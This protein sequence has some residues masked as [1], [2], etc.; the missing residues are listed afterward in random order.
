MK[1]AAGTPFVHP[2]LIG[3]GQV[4]HTRLKPVHHAFVYGTYFLLLPMRSLQRTPAP[5]LARNRWAPLSFADADHGDGRG[6]E[7]GGALAWLDALLQTEGITDAQGEVWL[8]TYPRVWGFTFK[9]VSFW[10]CHHADGHL[11]AVLV[12]VNNTFGERHC[13]LL[14]A[15]Q[16][17]VEQRARKVFHV[18]PFCP[19]E[20]GYRFRFM[21]TPDLS[22]TLARVDFDDPTGPLIQTSVSG[23]LQPLTAQST[24]HALLRYPLMT[25]AVVLRI[26]WQAAKLFVKKAPFFRKPTP[27][28][29]FTTR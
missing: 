22:R 27:P 26:H 8:H 9:P 14:D 25:L 23:A 13:Y 7:Q 2:P 1:A 21:L 6:A 24:R 19:V 12:E 28:I 10:Y 4:R 11:R 29:S 5:T 18:S 15:P 20:G 3:F 17:G 16:F